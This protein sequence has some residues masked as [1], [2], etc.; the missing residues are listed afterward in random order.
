MSRINN[1]TIAKPFCRVCHDAGKPESQYT[2]H[3]VRKTK[4]PNSEI[5]CPIILA[6]ECRYCHKLGHTIAKCVLRE[7]NN[8]RR[9]AAPQVQPRVAQVAPLPTKTSNNRYAMFEE[10]DEDDNKEHIDVATNDFPSL[11]NNAPVSASHKVSYASA[12][13]SSAAPS[14]WQTAKEREREILRIEEE[15][16]N[17]YSTNYSINYSLYETPVEYVPEPVSDRYSHI[18]EEEEPVYIPSE[19]VRS[20]RRVLA[21]DDDW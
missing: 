10:D 19:A 8:A 7:Q 18:I 21:E 3:F 15:K 4:N 1:S 14:K 11:G 9:Y 2:S 13:T 17:N 12:F 20:G 5:T 6:T 16:R